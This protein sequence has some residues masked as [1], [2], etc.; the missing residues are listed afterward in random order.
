MLL[1]N[2]I[3]TYSNKLLSCRIYIVENET[4]QVLDYEQ[5][6]FDLKKSNEEKKPYW[7]L[8][9]KAS[10][11]YGVKSLL[12]YN[13]IINNFNKWE[14]YVLNQYSGSEYGISIFR[15]LEK[16]ICSMHYEDQ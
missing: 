10:E 6:R 3:H 1:N 2:W 12:E 16:K 9:Y 14:D 13:N 8:A 7:Y 15:N 4:K 5:Y 11:F